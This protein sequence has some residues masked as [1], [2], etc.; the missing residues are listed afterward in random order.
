VGP[1][2]QREGER[3]RERGL[4]PTGRARLSDTEGMRARARAGLG[5]MGRLG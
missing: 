2:E 4:A 3:A 1:T 5:L